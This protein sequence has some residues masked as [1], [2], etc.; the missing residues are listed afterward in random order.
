MKT[1]TGAKFLGIG[2]GLG[3]CWVILALVIVACCYGGLVWWALTTHKYPIAEI[4][5]DNNQTIKV[6]YE[7]DAQHYAGP[8]YY[9]IVRGDKVVVPATEIGILE[10]TRGPDDI[11]V[12]FAQNK[13]LVCVYDSKDQYGS[14]LFVFYNA[15]TGESWLGRGNYEKWRVYYTQL[16]AENPSLPKVDSLEDR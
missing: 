12:A 4:E 10:F 1:L 15:Q 6:W 14:G 16:R 8:H 3:I 5:L 9:E 13:T 2:I 11:Q 7:T